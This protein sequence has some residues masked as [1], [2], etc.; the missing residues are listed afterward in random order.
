MKQS[1]YYDFS[2][3][4]I[5]YTFGVIV[6]LAIWGWCRLELN[7]DILKLLPGTPSLQ[8]LQKYNQVFSSLDRVSI[9]LVHHSQNEHELLLAADRAV[10]LLRANPYFER[11]QARMNMLAGAEIRKFYEEQI[12]NLLEAEDFAELADKVGAQNVQQRLAEIWEQQIGIAPATSNIRLDPLQLAGL[13]WKKLYW[14]IEIYQ[15]YLLAKDHRALLLQVPCFP[16]QLS[17]EE[18][19]RCWEFLT[20][21]R[22]K[23]NAEF[24]GVDMVAIGGQRIAID[25]RERIIADVKWTS[26]LAMV[27]L[28]VVFILILRNFFFFPLFFLPSLCG[29]AVG[30]GISSLFSSQLSLLTLGCGSIV[31]GITVDYGIHYLTHLEAEPSARPHMII[32]HLLKP[33]S[34]AML[35][36]CGAMCL[37]SFSAFPAYVE[38]GWFVSAGVFGSFLFAVVLYPRIPQLFMGKSTRTAWCD[39]PRMLGKLDRPR[40]MTGWKVVLLLGT[41]GLTIISIYELPKLRLL[42]DLEQ[43]SY[44]SRQTR[45]DEEKFFA[46]WG[47][48]RGKIA[49]VAQGKSLEE[50]LQRND[51]IYHILRQAERHGEVKMVNLAARLLPS[52]KRM[53]ASHE[54]WKKY[55][56]RDKQEQVSQTFHDNHYGFSRQAFAPFFKQLDSP[57]NP[58]S[59]ADLWNDAS[60]ATL[61]QENVVTKDHHWYVQNIIQV[62]NLPRPDAFYEEIR[63]AAPG[64]LIVDRREILKTTDTLLKKEVL[65]LVVGV[66]IF[67]FV[68]LQLYFLHVEMILCNFIPLSLSIL[69]TLGILGI[70][71]IPLDLF[72]ILVIVFIFGLGVDFTVLQTCSYLSTGGLQGSTSVSRVS[73]ILGA[74]TTMLGFGVLIFAQHPA[75]YSLGLC[76]TIGIGMTLANALWITPAFLHFF[77]PLDRKSHPIHWYHL[78][79]TFWSGA[80]YFFGFLLLATLV[81]PLIALWQK[82]TRQ[83]DKTVYLRIIEYL[84]KRVLDTDPLGQLTHLHFPPREKLTGCV[85]VANHANM[86]DI[87]LF[88]S[89]PC[90]KIT[91]VKWFWKI[92]LVGT[93]LRM[94]G[95][96]PLSEAQEISYT[97]QR[98]EY[99]QKMLAQN[100]N[101]FFFPEGTRAQSFQMGRFHPGAFQL[102]CTAKVPI[103]PICFFNSRWVFPRGRFVVRDFE[104][105]ASALPFITPDNFDY[106]LG[107]K[108][109]ARHAKDLLEEEYEHIARE[110]ACEW[111]QV[112]LARDCYIYIAPSFSM[113]LF[114]KLRLDPGY[115]LLPRLLPRAGNILDLG[116]GAGFLSNLLVYS[117]EK[118][119]V[120]G[121]DCDEENIGLARQSVISYLNQSLEFVR[122]DILA[123]VGQKLPCDHFDGVLCCDLLHYFPPEQQK[124]VLLAAWKTMKPGASLVMRQHVIDKETRRSSRFWYEMCERTI[125]GNAFRY[126]RPSYPSEVQILSWLEEI[127]FVNLR[128]PLHPK[129][130]KNQSILMGE[131]PASCS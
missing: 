100:V 114:F 63:K 44:R 91:I 47:E 108:A 21:T 36:T 78:I 45:Q 102:A 51:H 87:P 8:S 48:Q 77:L 93:V 67:I 50:A 119:H 94:A 40:W 98:L 116:C 17:H 109:L 124:E 18:N 22:K 31:I 5:H 97:N 12:P 3:K 42:T 58:Q 6:V 84:N 95:F 70:L 34:F 23:I 53:E 56:S 35:A 27:S 79:S 80:F 59:V 99:C 71:G 74:V 128:S 130:Q 110:K 9:T 73:V 52:L 57:V 55:W 118:R 11:A 88:N 69:W 129:P 83:T 24:P 60:F 101:V 107:A 10:E 54:M 2:L 61:F 85:L 76:A 112:R 64:A 89:L 62:Q 104:L 49:I 103:L 14:D 41:L 37:L 117:G 65:W 25:N 38:L 111:R 72:N 15:G 131:K 28:S 106:A 125:G 4:L 75:L 46:L 126:G 43:F 120:L 1:R 26:L 86:S 20:A 7:T 105:I 81:F 66:A 123:E 33:F 127:G 96:I 30:A 92:P 82:I 90:D 122:G 32:Q 13:F 115:R 29:V 39:L 19:V 121:I 113:H 16:R 68:L